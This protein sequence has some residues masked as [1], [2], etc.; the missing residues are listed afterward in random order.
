M[1]N[2]FNI[3]GI[4]LM[5]HIFSSCKEKPQPPVLSTDPVT[6]ITS[7]SA[8]SGGNVTDDGNATVT[9]KGV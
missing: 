1:R 4:I 6:S 7:T 8:V 5:I 3:A 9:A 2:L